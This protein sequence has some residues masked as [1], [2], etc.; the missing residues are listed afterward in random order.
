MILQSS[1]VK[2]LRELVYL[3]LVS[4]LK[5]LALFEL[6]QQV[7]LLTLEPCVGTG[8]NVGLEFELSQLSLEILELIMNIILLILRLHNSLL[9]FHELVSFE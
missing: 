7:L 4:I 3:L 2:I 8:E 1:L 6:G 9:E 5:V